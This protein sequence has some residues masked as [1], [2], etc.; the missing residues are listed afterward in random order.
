MARPPVA[1]TSVLAGMLGSLRWPL[2]PV[3]R[4]GSGPQAQVVLLVCMA[5]AGPGA[6]PHRRITEPGQDLPFLTPVLENVTILL[7]SLSPELSTRHAHH[8]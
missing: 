1:E 4:L 2:S 5:P 8:T 3:M 7:F 6:A